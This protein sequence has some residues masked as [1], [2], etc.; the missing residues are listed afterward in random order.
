M[1]KAKPIPD[2]PNDIGR[3]KRMGIHAW[4]EVLLIVPRKYEDFTTV[5]T[6][7]RPSLTGEKQTLSLTVDSRPNINSYQPPRLTVYVKDNVGTRAKITVFGGIFEWKNLHV[8]QKILVRGVVE[9]W[10]DDLQI[11]KIELID[12]RFAGKVI[13]RYPSKKGVVSE[14]SMYEKT[15]VAVETKLQETTEFFTAHYNCRQHELMRLAGIEKFG[16]IS[17]LFKCLHQPISLKQ[18]EDA[19]NGA[20]K[21]AIYRIVEQARKTAK[22]DP[23]PKSVITVETKDIL[24]LIDC[25]PWA[26]SYEQQ[27]AINDIIKDLK[28]PFAMRRLLSGDVGTGK[29]MTFLIP[30]LAARNSGAKV[31]IMVPNTLLVEQITKEIIQNFSH[32]DVPCPV[33]SITGKSTKKLDLSNNPII[34]ATSAIL[35]R[36]KKWV[37]DILIVD[38]QHKWSRQMREQ[39]ATTN[40]NILEAT[41]TCIPRTAA[42]V[43]HGGM[44][45]SILRTCP[46]KKNI[47]S[48]IVYAEERQRLLDHATKVVNAGFQVAFVYPLVAES[49][50]PRLSVDQAFEMWEK[51]FPGKVAK[52]HG[53][54]TDEEKKLVIEEIKDGKYQLIIATTVIE[55]GLTLKFLKMLVIVDAS[56][57]GVSTLHQLRGRLVR[58]GGTG[59]FFM[60]LQN[61]VAEESIQRLQLLEQY[62]DGFMLA[63]KDME[64]RG[65]GDLS[66]ESEDQNG[67]STTLFRGIKILPHE[68]AQYEDVML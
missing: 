53:K 30:A 49:N 37:P 39:L 13:P 46:V 56:R 2:D 25:L 14:L 20:K 66:D 4:E 52:L 64:L 6:D 43:S 12:S 68:L 16:S 42:L 7:I 32:G 51:L 10:N 11:N 61:E 18:A 38:E 59:Y 36:L 26:L 35:S 41:A 8:G 33:L 65:F 15:R 19:L 31:V 3:L 40:T 34:V 17:N 28:K 58:L 54:M 9:Y 1:A 57:Y 55:V 29:T 21:L 48:R 5:N 50:D 45:V 62:S 22:R 23:A 67:N 47:N 63:E 24:A 60:Y 27:A 44:N